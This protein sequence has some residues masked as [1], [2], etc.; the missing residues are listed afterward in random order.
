[1]GQAEHLADKIHLPQRFATADGQ[2]AV[3]APVVAVAVSGVECLLRGLGGVLGKGPCL[4]VVA[5]LAAHGAPLQEDDI[6][7][8]GTIDQAEGLD[9]M[10]VA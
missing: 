1:M 8:A 5:V 10:D 3:V 7:H 9:R 4:G 2:A 6:P